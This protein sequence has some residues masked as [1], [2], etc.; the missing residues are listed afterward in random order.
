[1]TPASC[2]STCFDVAP[3]SASAAIVSNARC[4]ANACALNSSG[5]LPNSA[6]GTSCAFPVPAARPACATA[7]MLQRADELAHFPQHQRALAGREDHSDA[8][9][10]ARPRGSR[11]QELPHHCRDDEQ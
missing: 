3:A 8:P 10:L 2:S 4:V 9:I 1:M 6:T 7:A 5:S 11:D